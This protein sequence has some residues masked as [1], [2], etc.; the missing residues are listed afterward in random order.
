M[1]GW[2][3]VKVQNASKIITAIPLG[4][5]NKRAPLNLGCY[6]YYIIITAIKIIVR[7]KGFKK[8]KF[9]F[10]GW[11]LNVFQHSTHGFRSGN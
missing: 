2:T 8:K 9:S 5:N 3:T 7:S 10:R 4:E 1:A 6:G 11:V